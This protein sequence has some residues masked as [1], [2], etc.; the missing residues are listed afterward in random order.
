MTKIEIDK[1]TNYVTKTFDFRPV[2]K[3][4]LETCAETLLQQISREDKHKS[5]Q[6]SSVIL[7]KNNQQ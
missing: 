3:T 1:Q 4:C 6:N 2:K 7:S 5:P